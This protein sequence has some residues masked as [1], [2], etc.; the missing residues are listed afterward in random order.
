MTGQSKYE[1]LDLDTTDL[2]L[3]FKYLPRSD[4]NSIRLVC[5]HFN[6][7]VTKTNK[8]SYV[9]NIELTAQNCQ[10]L[11]V[12]T[13]STLDLCVSL[14][15]YINFDL[16]KTESERYQKMAF[17]FI[18]QMRNRIV[19]LKANHKAG[20][21]INQISTKLT[22]LRTIHFVSD[23]TARNAAIILQPI[24]YNHLT[25]EVLKIHKA[26]LDKYFDIPLPNLKEL[27][28]DGVSGCQLPLIKSVLSHSTKLTTLWLLNFRLQDISDT[29][30]FNTN[31][32][33]NFR[34]LILERIQHFENFGKLPDPKWIYDEDSHLRWY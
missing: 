3:I 5:K 13:N 21:F 27:Q 30:F 16:S 28:L 8:R 15:T 7:I 11:S 12:A 29:N 6:Q 22:K 34:K 26:R 23:Q 9:M 24:R 4:K 32:T 25:L 17:D 1:I 18:N 33:N 31:V 10:A 2:Y 19:G 20:E 14:P